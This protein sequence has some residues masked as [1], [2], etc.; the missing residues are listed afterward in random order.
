MTRPTSMVDRD[1]RSAK[2]WLQPVELARS[3]G[4]LPKELRL[5]QELA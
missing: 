1:D 4:F 3:F 5:L 2:F